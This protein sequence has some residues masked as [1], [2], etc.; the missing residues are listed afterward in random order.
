MRILLF[1][2]VLLC[3][4]FTA[5]AQETYSRLRIHLSETITPQ[6]LREL[7][8]DIDH[9]EYR[10]NQW[11]ESDFGTTDQATL[12][13]HNISFDVLIPDVG[14]YY[15]QR[16]RTATPGTME[17]KMRGGNCM[18]A[19]PDYTTPAGF[20]YGNMG[21]YFTYQEVMNKLDSLAILYP[22]LVRA[23]QPIGNYQTANGNQI[24]WLKISDNPNNDEN[25]PEILYDAVHHAREVVSVAQ[26]IYFMYYLCENY[27][28][29]NEIK[30]LVDNLELYFVP[31][32]NPDGYQY[33]EQ[34]QPGGG[35]MWRKNR[36]NNGGGTFGVDLN[37]NYGLGWGTNNQGSSPN[38]NSDTYR[39]PSAFSE[40]ETQAMRDFCNSR[41][42][43][44]GMNYH[45]YGNLLVYPWGYLAKNCDDSVAYRAFGADLTQYNA[46]KYGTDLETVGYSTNGSSDDWMYGETVTKPLIF[47]MTPEVGRSNDGFWPAVNR[48]LPLCEE[49][50][51]MNLQV[52]RYL[53]KYAVAE[54]ITPR[55]SSTT[56]GAI[57]YNI[58]RLGLDTPATFTVSLQALSPQISS[59]ASPKTYSNLPLADAVRDS[60]TYTL[61]S[62]IPNNTELRF[63]LQVSNGL[64]TE[65][66]TVKVYFGNV[67]TAFQDSCSNFSQ[68][69]NGGW[70]LDNTTWLSAGS[71][72]AENASGNYA[73]NFNK[74]LA[75]QTINL[76][77]AHRAELLFSAR[78]ELENSYDYVLLEAS[79][80]NGL[81]WTPLCAPHTQITANTNLGNTQVYT[82]VSTGWIEEVVNLDAWAGKQ[83][84]LQWTFMSDAGLH[85]RGFNMDNVKVRKLVKTG[86]GLNATAQNEVT[87]GLYPNPAH[88]QLSVFWSSNKAAQLHILLPTGQILAR[89]TLQPGTQ[90]LDVS[91]LPNGVYQVVVLD[92][93][94][95]PLTRERFSVIR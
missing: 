44:F 94:G 89:Q 28:S 67:Q 76:V 13:M 57:H 27:N 46:Y 42:F 1:A 36:R 6:T 62:G 68:W 20:S 29:S 51:F 64:S 60:L 8:I 22:N 21:G 49:A 71:S 56:N 92:E 53:L 79:D 15:A 4:H 16:N 33:N 30:Y 18:A 82:G 31:V 12:R 7:G 10:K 9:G 40:P 52:A 34:T 50:N 70:A 25:E 35:G 77:D 2:L 85:M 37:R 26:L 81:S 17:K 59:V 72:F 66:D 80:D 91:A 88:E 84:M 58:R 86:L 3:G 32:V 47:A 63:L 55:L 73:G 74:T 45:S 95:T 90:T 87:L 19:G 24:Y 61:S 78:Y 83:I 41:Q 43:R 11:F 54:D 48:I 75:S 38:T 69:T 65:S 5:T 39:G 23:R 93:A 14:A